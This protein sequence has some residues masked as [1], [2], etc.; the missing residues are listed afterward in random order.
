M[1][2][3]TT[4]EDAGEAYSATVTSQYSMKPGNQVTILL[5]PIGSWY[6]QYA[7]AYIQS[8]LGGK[9]DIASHNI[10]RAFADQGRPVP[11]SDTIQTIFDSVRKVPIPKGGLFLEK[12]QLWM[13]EGQYNF[14]DKI[15]FA[16]V[17]VGGNVKKY[18]LEFKRNYFH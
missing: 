11:G 1:R 5:I 2:G 13:G 14:S 12:S 15:K 18:I 6:I 3:Y 17:I 8:R 16:E 10:A 4:Q 9:D 7:Q